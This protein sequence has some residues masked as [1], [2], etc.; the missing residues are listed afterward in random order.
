MQESVHPTDDAALFVLSCQRA[1]HALVSRYGWTLLSE[2]ELVE[3]TL[4]AAAGA[5][6]EKL[7]P[8]VTTQYTIALCEACRQEIDLARRERAYADLFRYLYRIAFNRWPDSAEDIAQRALVLVY[9]QIERCE[10]PA[11]FLAFAAFKLRHAAQQELRQATHELAGPGDMAED[12]AMPALDESAVL[13]DEQRRALLDALGRLPDD[14]RRAV[15]VLRFFHE[16]S[17]DE[18][19]RRL[20]VTPNYVRVLRF[21]ALRRLRV[22]ERLRA[23]V[24]PAPG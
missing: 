15:L 7:E 5:R 2:R 12:P 6:L 8:F 18:I 19:G 21:D 9:E 14:R 22:D 24:D 11:A 17:D 23:H 1:V 3:L 4:A 13:A 20:S 16:L 10:N